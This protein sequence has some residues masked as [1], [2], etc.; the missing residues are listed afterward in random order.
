MYKSS[1]SGN[2]NNNKKVTVRT[3]NSCNNTKII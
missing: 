1:N 2:D 3:V